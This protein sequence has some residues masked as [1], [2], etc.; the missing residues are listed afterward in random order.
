MSKK[1]TIKDFIDESIKKHGENYDYS[2]SEYVNNHTKVKL[3]CPKHGLFEVRP[4]DHFSKNVG[5]NKC[6]NA[7]II[8][9]KNYGEKLIQKFNEK[10]NF[11]YD[12]SSVD[13]KGTDKKITIICKIHGTF[14]QYPRHHLNGCGCPKC[15]NVYKLTTDDFLSNAKKIHGDKYDYSL[16]KYINNRT[17]IKIICPD[18]GIFNPTP[19]D[20]ISKSS[21]CPVCNESKGEKTIREFLIKNSFNFTPQ[22]KFKECINPTTNY[23]LPFDFYL[24]DFNTC[25]EYD[26][27]LHFK[28]IKNFGGIENLKKIQKKDKIKDNYCKKNRIKLIRITYKENLEQKLMELKTDLIN[29]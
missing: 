23:R 7:G 2:L 5:C 1:K 24:S 17:K 26:G 28:S 10:H 18:H 4:N 19:N 20:H 27:I 12:Y 6:N 29:L 15:G 11:K 22:K 16:V 3:I 21:G 25:I 9:S 13:F 8:K 14:N